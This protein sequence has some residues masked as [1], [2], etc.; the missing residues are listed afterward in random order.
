V[1]VQVA[2]APGSDPRLRVTLRN[3][4]GAAAETY[5]HALPWRGVYSM[6]LLAVRT[7][8]AGSVLER[9]LPVDDP[10]PATVTLQPGETLEGD[11]PLAERFPEFAEAQKAGALLVFWAYR[12]Q[13]VGTPPLSWTGGLVIFPASGS[14]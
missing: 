10:G 11:I 8:P 14:G 9:S 7:D 12:F 13:P 4:S 1:D 6:L 5:E 3:T 2:R